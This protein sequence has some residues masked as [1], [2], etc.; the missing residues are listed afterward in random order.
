MAKKF[1]RRA[2]AKQC[3]L[4]ILLTDPQVAEHRA[5]QE[6]LDAGVIASH[7]R[8]S[9]RE[10]CL[11]GAP[12]EALRYYLG[13]PTVFGIATSNNMLLNPYPLAVESHRCFTLIVQRTPYG[14]DIYRQYREFHFDNP[15]EQGVAIPDTDWGTSFPVNGDGL[16]PN[17]LRPT[18]RKG[19]PR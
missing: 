2:L 9:V 8:Q 11:A 7:I 14:N 10:L 18:S 15:W 12:Q 16:R 19:L 17:T 13:G 1:I 5:R 6:G 3:P 4:R